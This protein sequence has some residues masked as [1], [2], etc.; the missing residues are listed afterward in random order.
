M[1]N[2]LTAQDLAQQGRYGDT[3]LVHMNPQEV[4]GLQ[5]LALANGTTMTRNPNTGMPEAFSLGGALG[6]LI[7]MG[8][9]AALTPFTGPLGAGLLVGG[10]SYA[11]TG[12]LG[13][14]IMS[15]LGAYG[16]GSLA[17]TFSK[18]GQAA[19]ITGS[20]NAELNKEALSG[21]T[22]KQATSGAA[23]GYGGYDPFTQAMSGKAAGSLPALT[24]N[25]GFLAQNPVATANLGTKA[26]P[27]ILQGES[28][29]D[30]F[31]RMGQN[32]QDYFGDVGRGISDLFDTKALTDVEGLTPEMENIRKGTSGYQRFLNAGGSGMQLASVPA[33][34]VM[35]GL[36]EKDI[37]GEPLV[38]PPDRRFYGPYG[39]LNLS[40]P[41]GLRLPMYAKEGGA[42]KGYKGGGGL[43]L[44]GLMNSGNTQ[45][46]MTNT[47]TGEVTDMSEQSVLDMLK[48]AGIVRYADGGMANLTPD[49]G[50]MLNGMGDGVSDDIPANIEGE[51]EA[52]L[53]DGEFIVPARIVSELGNGSSDAGAEKLYAMIDR[54]QGARKQTIGTNKEYAKDTNAERYLP[55]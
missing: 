11:M 49:Q 3:T 42:V 47:S 50:K 4:Q 25:S 38:I 41:T 31:T 29:G 15:G 28:F 17:D 1:N 33:S 32:S 18:T 27:K 48:Q 51:Q 36:E 37:Y 24:T 54:I 16:G 12:D 53:S 35:G 22:A 55:A 9:G 8:V 20:T 10:L 23:P 19:A 39:Q 43:G 40:G 46:T 2:L 30:K 7:P 21:L 26:T 6:S 34:A 44:K 45:G 14:G 13:T 5:S 52:A